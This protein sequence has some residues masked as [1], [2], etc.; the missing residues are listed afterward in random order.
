LGYFAKRLQWCSSGQLESVQ[1]VASHLPVA[2]PVCGVSRDKEP[3]GADDGSI[4]PN[5]HQVSGHVSLSI[6]YWVGDIRFKGEELFIH[7]KIWIN[8]AFAKHEL[9]PHNFSV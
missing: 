2:I 5:C 4:R 3:Y 8:L 6:G 9:A 7:C 1:V